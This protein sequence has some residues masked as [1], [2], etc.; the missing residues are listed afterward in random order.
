MTELIKYD[1]MCQAIA[2]CE[3]V[4]EVKTMRDQ[5]QALE[6]YAKQARNLDAEHRAARVR[7]R[8]E[9]RCG[10][11][12]KE[13]QR[14]KGG[15]QKK[16]SGQRGPSLLSKQKKAA[17]ISDRQAKTFQKVA[18]VPDDKFEEVLAR[19]HAKPTT[20]A[21]IAT[22]TPKIPTVQVHPDALSLWGKM[23]DFDREDILNFD[24][25]NLYKV[26]TAPM[27]RDIRR[28]APIIKKFYAKIEV[29]TK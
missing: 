17:G 23:T 4:D 16:N 13:V 9:R 7:I 11:L 8:A 28:L 24:V 19:P 6:A 1:A 29:I 20:S 10:Q 27:R 12:L 26:S 21:V 3:K 5:A 22:N 18:E 14:S 15:V 25:N 2:E